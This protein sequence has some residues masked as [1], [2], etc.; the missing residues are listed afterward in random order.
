MEIVHLPPAMV[1]LLNA[2]REGE[3]D[4]D[5]RLEEFRSERQAAGRWLEFHGAFSLDAEDEKDLENIAYLFEQVDEALDDLALERLLPPLYQAVALMERVN[6]RREQPHFSPQPA[7]ND[8]IMAAAAYLQGRGQKRGVLERLP[9]LDESYQSL[10]QLYR[11][12]KDELKSE[13]RPELETGLRHLK[14]GLEEARSALEAD[15]RDGLH[16]SLARLSG[17]AGILDHLLEWERQDRQRYQARYRRYNIPL[18]GSDLEL[19]LETGR[20]V[21][22]EDWRR[23]VRNLVDTVLPRLFG[24]WNQVRWLLVLPMED[25]GLLEEIDLGLERLEDAVGQLMVSE[26]TAEEALGEYAA[27]CESLHH[28]FSSLESRAL[29]GDRY[30]GT[31]AGAYWQ[32]GTGLL[33]GSVPLVA[34]EELLLRS[35]PLAE[36]G[37]VGELMSQFLRRPDLELVREALCLLHELVPE[38]EPDGGSV[39]DSWSCGFCGFVNPLGQHPCR[40]CGASPS[41]SSIEEAWEA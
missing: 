5:T 20:Q 17:G 15:D 16:D 4:V 34:L 22:R 6:K 24:F 12:R 41:A 18:V 32:V 19:A 38:P 23:G 25:R 29:R 26:I 11:L 40:R 8:F 37:E 31:P 3:A 13:V 33:A 28:L 36:W 27:A 14:R 39:P 21:P 1:G 35:P 30:A 10:R 7:V 9:M 2:L